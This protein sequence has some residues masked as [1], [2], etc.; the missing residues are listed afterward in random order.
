M[1][2]MMESSEMNP[3]RKSLWV[4]WGEPYGSDLVEPYENV[5]IKMIRID[6]K[7]TK[8]SEWNDLR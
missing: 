5:P 4:D 6:E 3:M 7:W 2:E 1:S 8:I